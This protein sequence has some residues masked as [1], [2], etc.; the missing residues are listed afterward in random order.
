MKTQ[1]T[2]EMLKDESWGD[3]EFKDFNPEAKGLEISNGNLHLLMKTRQQFKEIL[4]EM[5]F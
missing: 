3:F 1:I 4:V 2:S 5:G